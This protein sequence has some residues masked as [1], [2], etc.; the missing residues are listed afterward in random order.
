MASCVQTVYESSSSESFQEPEK[1]PVLYRFHLY[2]PLVRH[3]DAILKIVDVFKEKHYQDPLSIKIFQWGSQVRTCAPLKDVFGEGAVDLVEKALMVLKD[4]C[5]DEIYPVPLNIPVFV[6]PMGWV[7]DRS[8]IEYAEVPGVKLVEH[9]FAKA[10]VTELQSIEALGLS[11]SYIYEEELYDYYTCLAHSAYQ[12]AELAAFIESAPKESEALKALF[13]E[14]DRRSQANLKK[15]RDE[16]LR[17]RKVL[18]EEIAYLEEKSR[19][20]AEENRRQT[21]AL[22]RKIDLLEREQRVIEIC[23]EIEKQK[24]CQL[25]RENAWNAE[26]LRRLRERVDDDSW[27]CCIS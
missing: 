9:E 23:L 21:D 13:D 5:V 15:V 22:Y 8:L 19:K 17:E 14:L 2:A 18:Q 4:L 16:I 26:E 25:E 12:E 1:A 10:I 20:E 24:I 27:S 11:G 3:L 6:K 7:C